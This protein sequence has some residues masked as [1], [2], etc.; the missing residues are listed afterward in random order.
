MRAW[1]MVYKFV[2]VY[3]EVYLQFVNVVLWFG[4]L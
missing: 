1:S 4:V 2:I 3:G